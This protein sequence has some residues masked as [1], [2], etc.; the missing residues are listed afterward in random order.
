VSEAVEEL[1]TEACPACE[2]ANA[3]DAR[4]CAGCGLQ[5]MR[6]SEAPE[7]LESVADPLIGRVIAD[8]YKILTLL[9]RG[10]MG[11]VYKV[12]HVHIGKLMAVKLLH[13]EL[14]RDRDT[15]KRFRREAEAASRLS[16]PNTVQIFDF[17][18]DQ[19]LMYLVMEFLEGRDFGW[20]I[21]H[22]GPLAFTR[23]ARICAQVCA[24]TAEAHAKGVIHRDLKPENVMVIQGRERPDMVKVLDF[25]LAKLRHQDAG[26]SLTR[27]GSIIGTPYY[28]A[29]EHIR[30]D[31]VD[32]RADVY[33][34][35]AVMYKAVAGVP[36]F[37]ASTPMGVLT[38]HL[39]DDLVPPSER[40]SRRDLPPEADAIIMRA[41]Q[42]EADDRY[43]HMD[44]LR[45][46][47]SA[48]LASVGEEMSDS[49]LSFPVGAS[50]VT[51]PSGRRMVVQVATRSDVDFYE[52]RI[53]RKGWVGLLL[54]IMALAG[55]SAAGV[56]LYQ[57]RPAETVTAAESEP[58]STLDSA[59]L[60]PRG[61]TLSGQI[62]RRQSIRAGDED[63]YRIE[64]PGGRRRPLTL[65]VTALPNIDMSVDIVKAGVETPVLIANSG[66]VG[67]A[68]RVPNFPLN[69]SVYYLRVRER[70][71][72]GSMP[73]ENI[74]DRYS[75]SWDYAEIADG[76]EEE[77][78][79]SLELA[80][81]IDPSGRVRGWIGWAGDIDIYCLTGS[82]SNV[83]AVVD[84]V[85]NLDLVLRVVDRRLSSSRKLDREGVGEGE[86]SDPIESAVAGETCFEVSVDT[87]A[88]AAARADAANAYVLR[89]E[90]SG[91]ASEQGDAG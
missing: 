26:H 78:N 59:N 43:Q 90:P 53:K 41:M 11:V 65:E 29:P 27:A 81:S 61:V 66:G 13:G 2:R 85:A 88:S 23:V 83:V 39:T 57:H 46:D 44:E 25:G 30:G 58:N 12:E 56:W 33:S 45:H 67:R 16:H 32:P 20:L 15:V 73:T 10:G 70:R 28:M 86:R 68:E 9:G 22:E 63:I 3:V 69:G 64:N 4:F 49:S 89:V 52:R 84:G 40:S 87:T 1:D 74:S 72:T 75:I 79:D 62:G 34:M 48:Y 54:F 5:L 42:R 19:G 82:A 60:L 8:R 35:G 76:D 55:L 50:P 47:L 37:W 80:G 91:P 51:S 17:G 14:A 71:M 31:E 21:Q 38:K 24:S 36:P 6:D 18:R 7:S 77:I